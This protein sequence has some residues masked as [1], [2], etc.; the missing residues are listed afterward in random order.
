MWVSLRVFLFVLLVATSGFGQ[1]TYG[2]I[3]GVVT[4]STGAV[5][6][7]GAVTVT[8]IETNIAKTVTTSAEG[9]YE[10]THL[11][12]GI[13]RVRAEVEGFKA[14]VRDGIVVESRA[15]VR[16]NFQ[17]EVG[18]TR[19]EVQVTTSAPVIET[20]TAQ[21][22]DTRTAR[23]LRDLP[24]LSN[25]STFAYLL[26]L[27]GSQSVS[28]N[29]Y[30]FN[31][32]RSAQVDIMIDGISAPRSTTALGGTHNTLAMV[33]EVRQQGSN[34][35][36]EFQAPGVVSIVTR[37]GTNQLRGTLLYQHINSAL[38]ARDFFSPKKTSGRSHTLGALLGGPV[39][40]PRLYD[41]HDRTFFTLSLW[42]ERVPGSLEP[43]ATVPTAAMRQGDFSAL[44]SA[45]TDPAT[46]QPFPGNLV[47]PGRLSPVASRVQERFYPLPNFGDPNVLTG[48]N[49]RTQQARRNLQNRWEARLDQKLSGK[50]MVYARFSWRGAVQ[51]PAETLPTIPV[52]N[53]Y[54]R[55][56]TFVLSDTH[57][58]SGSLINEFRFG[59]QSS[60][61]QVLGALN[62]QE[63]L[64]Y[65]GIQGISPP[66][67]YRG[68]PAFT[69][70]ALVSNVTSTAHTND[71]YHSF[72]VTDN[73]TWIRGKHTTKWGF[74]L[75]HNGNEGVNVSVGA[76][77]QF[78]FNG[79]FTGNA[80]ADF[81]LGLP[82]RASRS[83]FREYQDIGGYSQYLFIEDAWR[84][85]PKI[86]LTLGARYEY[87]F[88]FTDSEG[89][90]YNLDPRTA[91]LV[92]PD[93]AF[94]SGRIN[95]LLP[96]T[97]RVV[98]SSQAGYPQALR[99][100]DKNNVVPRVGLAVRP[101]Q[102]T[103]FRA[104]YGMF[105]DDFG[106]SLTPPSGGP[107]YAFTETF[108]NTNR[109]QP[110]YTFPNPFGVAGSIGTI[111]AGG[112]KVDL[113]NP[114]AQQWNLTIEREVADVGVRLSYIGTKGTNLGYTRELNVPLPSITS[115]SNSRRP[116]PQ[117]G[118]LLFSDNGGNSIYHGLQADAERRFGRGLY[119]QA[120]WTWSNLISDV[121]DARADLGPAIESP[122]DRQRER[123]RETYSV[124]HR[125]TGSLIYDL[126]V[127]RGRR[128]LTA[129][130]AV[131]NAVAGGWTASALLYFETGRYFTPGYT[132]RDISGT[133]ATAGRPDR[134]ANGNLPPSERQV[135][136]WFDPAAFT[137]PAANSGRFG[138][139][140]VN[141]LEGP[142][143]NTQ[144]FSVTKRFYARN[145]QR[146][147]EFQFS[148]LNLFNHPNFNLPTANISAPST[149]AQVLS[150]RPYVEAAA[151]RTMTG[152]LRLNF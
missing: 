19:A 152:I 126:P 92:A 79:Y 106:F 8:N 58:F 36:A 52:R 83:T 144:H 35:S 127:G 34:N 21:L 75:M 78:T 119:F 147:L 145:E 18:S 95:P 4:D 61:N 146:N 11:L 139:C 20:E 104:G 40:L 30:S 89:L 42:G 121:G 57:T 88:A 45:L 59:R 151:T 142:G 24:S 1:S 105:I 29:T 2:S 148:I 125:L 140:G 33:S 117:Y 13:Y 68:M 112:F 27:P 111:T 73:L 113:G 69:F 100:V 102:R 6:V 116:Y 38:N 149:V 44:A 97:I 118:S 81:L 129:L 136:R 28:V 131:L 10:A 17:M 128:F 90:M 133:G 43:N 70:G 25:E 64:R 26:T 86:T 107:L 99:A 84:I 53:G 77:G 108:Q 54:R 9:N 5:I 15:A 87:Q 3:V 22:A 74:D 49:L 55:G 93:Q 103:V 109:R 23:Q 66:G 14:S 123:G 80:Y 76:F 124:R 65:T 110:Q 32:S 7:G 150:T 71:R 98:K 114:Y 122:F 12:P 51:E 85:N 50:N 138:N 31:G 16:I 67:D 56:S 37:A 91:D 137:V 115:F 132:G 41:G 60:P 134:L 120:A 143:L 82:E 130:P 48:A 72:T 62:G 141:I 63:V 47:P 135:T 96:S 94:G 39:Y 46:G 101:F